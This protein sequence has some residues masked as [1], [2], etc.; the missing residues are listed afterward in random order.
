MEYLYKGIHP[1]EKLRNEIVRPY[2]DRDLPWGKHYDLVGFS[3]L[4][5]KIL[6]ELVDKKFTFKDI[7]Q[8]DSPTIGEFMDMMTRFPILKAHGYI[9][10]AKRH[11]YRVSVEGLSISYDDMQSPPSIDFI[12]DSKIDI[13]SESWLRENLGDADEFTLDSGF[14]YY[15]RAWWD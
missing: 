4:P 6:K 10:T 7:A 3:D 15:M 13:P 8:N 1:D 11:D 14:D 12:K 5:L 9:V 2:L